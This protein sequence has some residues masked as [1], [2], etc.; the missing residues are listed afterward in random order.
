MGC[1]PW[2]QRAR[3]TELTGR[4]L[5]AWHAVRN[6]VVIRVPLGGGAGGTLCPICRSLGSFD[7][8]GAAHHSNPVWN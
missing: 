7:V 5:E 1:G 2:A 8:N 3:K 6:T 4:G